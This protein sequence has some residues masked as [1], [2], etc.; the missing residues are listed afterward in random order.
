MKS[1]EDLS[2]LEVDPEKAKRYKIVRIIIEA[3]TLTLLTGL[4]IWVLIKYL[5]YFIVLSKNEEMRNEFI[6]KIKGYGPASFFI[7]LGLQIFQVI[8]MIIPSGPIVIASGVVLNP[9]LAVLVCLLGQT[10]G[11]IIVYILVKLL[12][13]DFLALFVDPN[14]IKNSKLFGNRTQTEVMM[15][16]YLMIPALPKDIVAF[17]APFTKVNVWRFSLINIVARIPMTIVSVMLG[18]AIVDG[19]YVLAFVLA[20]LSGL[21]A[22]LCFIFNKKIVNFLDRNKKVETVEVETKEEDE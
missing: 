13:Y 20:G 1:K 18:T 19:N 22:L 9:F 3:V 21:C 2:T 14:K 15:F 17:I 12:G 11:G 7:I 8:F 5:P 4:L 10:I 6:Q 16:G